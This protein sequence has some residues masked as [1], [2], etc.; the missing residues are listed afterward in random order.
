MYTNIMY[1]HVP[2]ECEQSTMTSDPHVSDLY[3]YNDSADTDLPYLCTNNE[4][5]RMVGTD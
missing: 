1:T 2:I 5:Y 3:M 4:L